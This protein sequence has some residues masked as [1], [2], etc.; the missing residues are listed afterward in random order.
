MSEG[1][2]IQATHIKGIFL[3][4]IEL[5][6]LDYVMVGLDHLSLFLSFWTGMLLC[7]CDFLCCTVRN[8]VG[9]FLVDWVS[10]HLT[11]QHVGLN[12]ITIATDTYA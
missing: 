2:K 8:A 10:M 5:T 12:Y 4:F 9:L 6:A 11:L 3:S 7:L 1:H